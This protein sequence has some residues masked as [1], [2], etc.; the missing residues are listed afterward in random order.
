[1]AAHEAHR[2]FVI[3]KKNSPELITSIMCAGPD[4]SEDA[5][6]V[7]TEKAAA[8]LYLTQAGWVETETV[9]EL[10][11]SSFLA[12]LNEAV[13]AGPKLIAVDPDR[14]HQDDGISQP[15]I[16]AAEFFDRLGSMITET[17]KS[18]A[19]PTT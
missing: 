7:F 6:A 9:A 10:E 1:M 13:K 3:A 18:T 11:T 12:W 16:P 5:V 4:C 15:V 8:E 14:V 17:L 2:F 19:L